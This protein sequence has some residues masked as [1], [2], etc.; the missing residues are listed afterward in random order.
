[1]CKDLDRVER[2]KEWMSPL[3]SVFM[4]I[5]FFNV[6]TEEA[7]AAAGWRLEAEILE[8]FDEGGEE[9]M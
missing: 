9:E 1:M 5:V 3:K 8:H 4:P 2:I 6:V 7:A